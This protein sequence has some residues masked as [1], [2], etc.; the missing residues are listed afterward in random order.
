MMYFDTVNY[1][2]GDILV[3]VDRS[4]MSNGLE[5]RSPFL[6]H[7]LFCKAWRVPTDYKLNKSSRKIILKE[8]LSKE[9][10]FKLLER[11]KMGFGIPLNDILRNEL[12]EWSINN[13]E[14]GYLEKNA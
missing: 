4:T 12:R 5:A 7:N 14:S 9:I 1:L 8:I 10:D 13:I 11:P 2:P 6:D 3:K